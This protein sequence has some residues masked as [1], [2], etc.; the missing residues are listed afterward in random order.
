MLLKIFTMISHICMRNFSMLQNFFHLYRSHL[1]ASNDDWG[2]YF[3]LY[4][5]KLNSKNKKIL[6][7]E[8]LGMKVFFSVLVYFLYRQEDVYRN[9]VNI[10]EGLFQIVGCLS[11]RKAVICMK[12]SRIWPDPWYCAFG[13]VVL[14]QRL[15]LSMGPSWW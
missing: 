1:N 14:L 9:N 4:W 7:G 13:A 10:T 6:R 2:R 5:R 8:L 15:W 11:L 12:Q 3:K